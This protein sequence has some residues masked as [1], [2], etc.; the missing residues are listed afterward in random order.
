MSIVLYYLN[1]NTHEYYCSNDFNSSIFDESICIMSPKNKMVNPPIILSFLLN[2][3]IIDLV[4]Y[5]FVGHNSFIQNTLGEFLF[6]IFHVV[7]RSCDN[8]LME[9]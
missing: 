7:F 6:V 5:T 9:I 2:F 8:H 3:L 4:N 1:V